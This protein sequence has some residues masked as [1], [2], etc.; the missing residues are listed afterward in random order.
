MAATTTQRPA[1]LPP[2]ATKTAVPQGAAKLAKIYLDNK[3][4]PQRSLTPVPVDQDER[5]TAHV[6]H[7]CPHMA[8]VNGGGKERCSDKEWV[9]PDEK[10]RFCPRHGKHLE[11]D[12]PGTSKA[13]RTARAARTMHGRSAVPWLIPAGA[14]LADAAMNAAQ[15]GGFQVSLSAPVLAGGAYLVAR[16][17]LT[18]RAI[19]R[20]RIEK[21]QREGKRYRALIRQSQRAAALVAE[22]SLWASAFAAT[23][24]TSTAGLIVAAAGMVRWAVGSVAWWKTAEQ[25]RTRGV[26]PVQVDRPST[27]ATVDAPDPVKLR[28]ET[29][30]NT[31]IGC[32][33]GA[34]PGTKLAE[35][36]RLPGCAVGASGRTLLPN[37]SAKVV[38][39][40]AGTINMRANRPD[41]L[42]RLAAAF[43]CTYADVSFFADEGDVSVGWVRVQP[44]NVLAETRMW[45]GPDTTDWK[46]GVSVIGRFDDGQPILYSWWTSNGAAHDLIG[47]SSGSG[48]SELVAQLLLTSLHSNGLVLDWVGDP[49]GGQSFGVLKDQV[50][51]FARDKAEIKLMLLAAVKE[52]WRRNDELSKHNIKTW[53]ATTAMPLLVITL[54]EVQSYIDD[55][56]ILA[57]V[58]MLAGQARKCGIKLRLITQ[59]IA[60]YNLGGST[61]IKDQAKTGQT[62]TF[63]SQTDIAGRSAVEGDSPIDPTALPEKWG[64]NTCAAGEKTAGLVF[65][66]GVHG[67][68]VY[69]R[70]D[71]TGEDLA[72]WLVDPAG[73]PSV[74]PGRFGPEAQQE[75]GA[76]WGDRRERAIRLL[77]A[78]RD[79]ADLLPG[80]K[81]LELIEQAAVAQVSEQ[82][83][84]NPE[85]GQAPL[86]ERARDVVL[87]AA[88]TAASPD[89]LVKREVIAAAVKG[90]V[91]DSTF[92][93]ALAE[94][95][96]DGALRRVKNGLFE[97]PGAAKAQQ[98]ELEVPA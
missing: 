91:A 29:T 86:A 46:K 75:S 78:G 89:G 66:Q 59:I 64:P 6:L 58:E 9:L 84:R 67:R 30:W 53:F 83:V 76:L 45:T 65:V 88:L 71:Y 72:P 14:A 98:M 56:D 18:R 94:L 37:W 2:T 90:K 16:R 32:S 52:M 61:Y 39:E 27:E 36:T 20:N 95:I 5:R 10:A 21:G 50:D 57:L 77:K 26:D 51:W 24:I 38:A 63:R 70:T 96:S 69:G 80:G 8:V 60:A 73:D 11:A 33:G 47:G 49:Q 40:A 81:A 97:V 55:P 74:T 35:I 7:Q 42:G 3:G 12:G 85:P 79:D 43:Q 4:L 31:R 22:A 41:L 28:A 62:L 15:V 25:R 17:T 82:V 19:A 93:N 48:K 34:F 1:A 92:A 54:D 13:A 68:D 23:D 87:S 44:D